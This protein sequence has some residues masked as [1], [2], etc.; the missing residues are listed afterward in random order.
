MSQDASFTSSKDDE[1]APLMES[2]TTLSHLLELGCE[3][4]AE[5]VRGRIPVVVAALTGR[6]DMVKEM[7]KYST[8]AQLRPLQ[9]GKLLQYL[10]WHVL[11]AAPPPP[12]TPPGKDDAS[13]V[14]AAR[15]Q[16]QARLL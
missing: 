12:S 9:T 3:P 14:P 6:A 2:F 11:M 4:C 10:V 7:L 8:A 15:R 1:Y 16:V 5:D 13:P